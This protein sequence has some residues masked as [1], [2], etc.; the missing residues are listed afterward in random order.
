MLTLLNYRA[1]RNEY[2][3]AA[4]SDHPSAVHSVPQAADLY[5]INC[6]S[7]PALAFGWI[8]SMGSLAGDE[9]TKAEW[10]KNIYFP[11]SLLFGLPGIDRFMQF[12]A[13]TPIMWPF[14]TTVFFPSSND[15]RLPPLSLLGRGVVKR[16]ITKSPSGRVLH[17]LL[18]C[19]P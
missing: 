8:W 10:G 7:L 11:G 6:K 15:R 1:T 14:P 17:H 16:S 9:R 4:P 12:K 3:L 13:I 19:F 5:C 18:L 2:F